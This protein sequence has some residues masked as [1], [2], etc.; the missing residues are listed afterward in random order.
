[1]SY[2][3]EISRQADADLRS[4]LEHIARNLMSPDAAIAQLDRLEEQIEGLEALPNR[5]QRYLKEPWHSRNLRI[6]PV[7]NYCIF[8]TVDD[9][10]QKVTILRV[11]YGGRD[12]E[13]QLRK[14][15]E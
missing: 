9:I 8:Y 2:L 5:F 12:A 14:L 10:A 15:T 6:M 13:S 1:M 3:V 4:I 11:L 7:D